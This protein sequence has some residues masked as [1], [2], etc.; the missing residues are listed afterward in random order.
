MLHPSIAPRFSDKY[1]G[2]GL[3]SLASIPAGTIIWHPTAQ[4]LQLSQEQA[5][6]LRSMTYEWLE[7]LGFRLSNG[8]LFLPA[9][10]ACLF[11]HSCDPNVVDYGT[12]FGV[13]TRDIH[14][15]DEVT[16]D[17]S[18]FEYN[19]FR[20]E[21]KCGSNSCR[22]IITSSAEGRK[23]RPRLHSKIDDVSSRYQPLHSSLIENSRSYQQLVYGIKPE[24]LTLHSVCDVPAV[25]NSYRRTAADRSSDTGASSC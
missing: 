18:T 12:D 1:Q 15:G 19:D 23:H 14:S 22:K 21:C 5:K 24:G 16:I 4:S 17:Y 9:G 8:N 13:A 7:E 2:L 11:N 20:L 3:F 10:W 25:E 6:K